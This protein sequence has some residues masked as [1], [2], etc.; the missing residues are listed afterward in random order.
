MKIPFTIEDL[1][2]LHNKEKVLE[3]REWLLTLDMDEIRKLKQS[4]YNEY[5]QA[6]MAS[7][8]YQGNVSRFWQVI[9][10]GANNQ[11]LSIKLANRRKAEAIVRDVNAGQ[12]VK[13]SRG[14]KM[15]QKDLIVLDAKIV[16]V[17]PLLEKNRAK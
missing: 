9:Y 11:L 12:I 6:E 5:M 2:V 8:G 17:E 1:G 7:R 3:F 13:G 10:D 16:E 4:A 15:S 14:E